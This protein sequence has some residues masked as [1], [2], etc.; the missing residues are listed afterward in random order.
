MQPESSTDLDYELLDDVLPGVTSA[1]CALRGELV[2]CR[3]VAIGPLVEYAFQA[4]A[5]QG[6][7]PSLPEVAPSEVAS[8]LEQVLKGRWSA[9]ADKA[10]SMHSRPFEFS[11]VP[12]RKDVSD[13]HLVAFVQRVKHAATRAGFDTDT[14]RKFAASFL[15]L[16]DNLWEHSKAPATGLVGYRTATGVFEFT[17]ADCGIGV[18]ASMNAK[19]EYSDLTDA[20]TALELALSL[21]GTE[22]GRRTGRGDGYR[23]MLANLSNMWGEIRVRSGDHGLTLDGTSPTTRE[24]RTFQ[25]THFQGF[26]VSVLC[27]P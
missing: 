3:A 5:S 15:E 19:A 18:V 13:P 26:F 21:S 17:I 8:A 27:R 11:R 16:A 2:G 6:V 14:A 1:A 12:D 4:A 20:G 23:N 22:Y 9:Q 7:L 25:T 10:T 24:Q